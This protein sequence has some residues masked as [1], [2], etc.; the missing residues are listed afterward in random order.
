M[1]PRARAAPTTHISGQKTGAE[2]AQRHVE[3]RPPDGGTVL[4]YRKMLGA[5][6]HGVKAANELGQ[7]RDR[8]AVL[9]T[10]APP[11]RQNGKFERAFSRSVG[12]AEPNSS[13]I[14]AE[15][16]HLGIRMRSEAPPARKEVDALD[17]V[18]LALGILA[19]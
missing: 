19:V 12:I 8:T 5:E 6:Q 1:P 13:G 14:F 9:L 16:Y 7:P 15:A 3:K 4:D 18:R 10:A 11:A 17:G 2:L